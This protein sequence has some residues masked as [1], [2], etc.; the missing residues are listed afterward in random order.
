MISYT[1]SALYILP[2]GSRVLLI[3]KESPP[4]IAFLMVGFGRSNLFEVHF[5]FTLPTPT[6][7]TLKLRFMPHGKRLSSQK[8]IHVHEASMLLVDFC[9]VFYMF[10][11]RNCWKGHLFL[12]ICLRHDIACHVSLLQAGG[13]EVLLR[14]LSRE[15]YME[16][17][18]KN[19]LKRQCISS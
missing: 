9:S 17:Y 5:F 18:G 13:V 19:H 15:P 4:L 14:E 2:N 11:C 10:V 6:E 1:I 3:Y 8:N 7:R 16:S 12:K